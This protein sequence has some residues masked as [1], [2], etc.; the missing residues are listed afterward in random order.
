MSAVLIAAWAK[1]DREEIRVH[2][3]RYKDT[4]TVDLRTWWRDGNDELRPGRSGLTLA[5]RHVPKLAEAL[6]KALEEAEHR[7]L[8]SEEVRT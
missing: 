3:D 2:L 7:G 5:V 8:L 1:N 4:D 6:T